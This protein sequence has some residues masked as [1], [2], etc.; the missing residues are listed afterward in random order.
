ML[1]PALWHFEF[2]EEDPFVAGFGDDDLD[3]EGAVGGFV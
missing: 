1:G 2:F 3:G